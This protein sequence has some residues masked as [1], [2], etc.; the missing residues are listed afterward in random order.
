MNR[1]CFSFFHTSLLRST[2]NTEWLYIFQAGILRQIIALNRLF[3]VLVQPSLC[4]EWS[5]HWFLSS[6]VATTENHWP[7]VYLC[8]S[9]QSYNNHNKIKSGQI[10]YSI[11]LSVVSVSTWFHSL[12]SFREG[13]CSVKVWMTVCVVSFVLCKRGLIRWFA[14]AI[15]SDQMWSEMVRSGRMWSEVIIGIVRMM[16]IEYLRATIC[17]HAVRLLRI[18]LC[19]THLLQQLGLLLPRC[20]IFLL[21]QMVYLVSSIPYRLAFPAPKILHMTQLLVLGKL[22]YGW[23]PIFKVVLEC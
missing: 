5:K 15:R 2:C 13:L 17:D 14:E 7:T 20:N 9:C 3:W 22:G 21:I 10:L 18:L 19:K 12:H 11:R 6:K 1:A 4:Q 8:R 23:G 16:I